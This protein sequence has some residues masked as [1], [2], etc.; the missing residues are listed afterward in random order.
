MNYVVVDKE[1]LE[2]DLTS[3]AD[4]IRA[5]GGTTEA[6]EFPL[7]MKQAVESIQTGITKPE[8][9][10]TIEITE[11]G[12]TEVTPDEGKVLSK[13]TVTTN[14]ESG[15]GAGGSDIPEH[16]VIAFTDYNEL[17]F[18]TT[19]IN[20]CTDNSTLNMIFTS[21][22]ANVGRIPRHIQKIVVPDHVT[23]IGNYSFTTMQNL[24]EISCWDNIES[25]G[26]GAFGLDNNDN[27]LPNNALSYTYFPPNLKYIGKISFRKNLPK[28]E[29]DI[30]DTVTYIGE[31][32]FFYAGNSNWKITKLPPELTYI[33]NSAFACY[34][35]LLITEIPETVDYIGPNAFDG[36]YDKNSLTLIKFRGKPSTVGAN[37]FRNNNSLVNIYVPWAEGE[38]ANAPWGA[39]NATI[40]YNTT[41]DAYGNPIVQEV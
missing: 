31:Q 18:P 4:S 5:K 12:T 16:A 34:R 39:T 13:V 11:N 36:N 23:V 41:Y 30:P 40:H 9:E 21:S 33:G 15:G 3:V 37:V 1:Q 38:V 27:A 32:A 2:A 20:N 10:K 22:I 8:Q 35:K 29:S 26:E 28:I 17:G 25:I 24:Q 19:L 14:V 7:G 6:L